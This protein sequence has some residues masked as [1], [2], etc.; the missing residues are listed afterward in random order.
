LLIGEINFEVDLL[1]FTT[2]WHRSRNSLVLL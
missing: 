2:P 1:Q